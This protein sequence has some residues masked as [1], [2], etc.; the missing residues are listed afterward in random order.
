MWKVECESRGGP[1]ADGEASQLE[2]NQKISTVYMHLPEVEAAQNCIQCLHT[3]PLKRR[4]KLTEYLQRATW[5]AEAAM[6]VSVYAKMY[7][8]IATLPCLIR[9]LRKSRIK[10]W[11]VRCLFRWEH[12]DKLDYCTYFAWKHIHY[13]IIS[14]LLIIFREMLANL[15]CPASIE[16]CVQDASV[17]RCRMLWYCFLVVA[18]FS[19]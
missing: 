9:T 19:K 16:V 7:W 17:E 2:L 14:V 18:E 5:I 12:T 10:T 13:H 11:C 1:N 15:P 6:S 8:Q 3:A 4:L